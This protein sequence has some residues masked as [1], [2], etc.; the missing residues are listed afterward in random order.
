MVHSNTE[1]PERKEICPFNF[2]SLRLS[3][4]AFDA[5][6][7]VGITFP[8]KRLSGASP[9]QEMVLSSVVLLVMTGGARLRRALELKKSLNFGIRD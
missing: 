9:H 5:N 3:D 8:D 7:E 1:P 4:F 2:A 6:S